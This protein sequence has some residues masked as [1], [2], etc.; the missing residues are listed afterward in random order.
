MTCPPSPCHPILIFLCY[1]LQQPSNV[2]FCFRKH[3]VVLPDGFSLLWTPLLTSS[4]FAAHLALPTNFNCLKL[5]MYP[6]WDS[7]KQRR[8]WFLGPFGSGTVLARYPSL[9]QLAV[10]VKSHDMKHYHECRSESHGV[11]PMRMKL[12]SD[13]IWRERIGRENPNSCYSHTLAQSCGRHKYLLKKQR[14]LWLFAESVM[15]LR[16]EP[17]APYDGAIPIVPYEG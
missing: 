2:L 5:S 12:K 1:K 16:R 7:C 4:I 15:L 11:T 10:E 13:Y 17:R 8:D 14:D 9:S 3:P 6:R